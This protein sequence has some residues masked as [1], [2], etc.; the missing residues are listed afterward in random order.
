MVAQATP[1][2]CLVECAPL[3]TCAGLYC[4]SIDEGKLALGGLAA[5]RGGLPMLMLQVTKAPPDLPAATNNSGWPASSLTT[6]RA[7]LAAVFITEASRR[8]NLSPSLSCGNSN[9]A[10]SYRAGLQWLERIECDCPGLVRSRTGR[11]LA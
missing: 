1:V 2:T 11:K 10:V 9:A 6:V 3:Q 5:A 4:S 7:Q 8:L